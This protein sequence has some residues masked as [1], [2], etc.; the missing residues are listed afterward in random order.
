MAMR[1]IEPEAEGEESEGENDGEFRLDP[2]HLVEALKKFHED[3]EARILEEMAL[4]KQRTQKKSSMA[5]AAEE[6]KRV[7]KTQ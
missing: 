3:K 7:Q 5:D 6:E 2:E 1:Q 4:G